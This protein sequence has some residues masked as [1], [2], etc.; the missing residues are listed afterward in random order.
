MARGTD[1]CCGVRLRP[2]GGREVMTL[3]LVPGDNHLGSGPENELVITQRGVSRAH[4]VLTWE[5]GSVRVRDLASKN[6][7]FVNNSRVLSCTARA[8][9]TL[10]FGPA[11][12]ALEPCEAEDST[13][14]LPLKP[15]RSRAQHKPAADRT[16]TNR[17]ELVPGFWLEAIAD[18]A[19]SSDE[20][21]ASDLLERLRHLAGAAAALWMTPEGGK[22]P[23]VLAAA[24]AVEPVML[25]SARD[26]LIAL[27]KQETCTGD[28][29][30]APPTH[31]SLV[32]RVVGTTEGTR[33]LTLLA[34]EVPRQQAISLLRVFGP[35]MSTSDARSARLE[36]RPGDRRGA[37][38]V[39]GPGSLRC[40]SP[41]MR[42]L[43]EQI[44]LVAGSDVPV[45][46]R[47]ESGAGKEHIARLIHDSSPRRE[48]PF[49][50]INCTA[51]PAD[52]LEAE[53]FGIESGVATGVVARAGNLTA[54]EGGTV[55]LDEIAD[56]S[57]T[58]QVKLL[59]VLEASEIYPVGARRPVPLDVRFLSATNADLA[60]RRV[61]G[62]FRDDLYH[63]LAGI[64]VV[65]PPLRERPQDIPLF[66]QHFTEVFAAKYENPVRGVTQAAL[67]TLMAY[68]WHGNVRELERMVERLV[69]ACPTR[70]PISA[71]H[72]RGTIPSLS[73]GDE[74]AEP[75]EDLSLAQ[76]VARAEKR[77]IAAALKRSNGLI[78][79]TARMLGISRQT[80]RS[81]MQAY[82]LT[83]G[84]VTGE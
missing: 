62:R 84:D 60:S 45:L 14:A 40:S 28:D 1:S 2:V 64:P 39:F 50:A 75:A 76:Q 38:L 4:A 19:R 53:L 27:A 3:V 47:G 83:A 55:L 23:V 26:A 11:V 67:E 10:T 61:E 16:P 69:L 20:E 78:A 59:R 72:V 54:A 21:K 65:I 32:L 43:Y 33:A 6:G 13:I 35:L 7:T 80:L 30:T 51:I 48:R 66:V 24:G 74:D 18:A 70:Q 77:T 34:P 29:Y 37:D 46:I 58:L 22:D 9:D 49:V 17:D 81:K 41:P 44:S 25:S 79:P 73:T 15:T 68:P 63:R 82:G 71:E 8:G 12:F 5:D 31:P 42:R 56:M 52:L 36:Q 57:P